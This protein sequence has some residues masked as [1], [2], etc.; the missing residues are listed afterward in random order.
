MI[1]TVGLAGPLAF[2]TGGHC[3]C[4]VQAARQHV[5]DERGCVPPEL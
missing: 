1:N 5:T 4:Y 2:V 3:L